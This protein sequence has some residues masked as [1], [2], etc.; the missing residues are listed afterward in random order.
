M[1][2]LQRAFQYEGQQVRTK[3]V[4]GRV[5]FAAKDIC[6]ILDI[7]NH[8]NAVAKLGEKQKGTEVMDTP[9]GRQEMAVITEAGVYKIAFTSQERSEE[10]WRFMEWFANRVLPSIAEGVSVWTA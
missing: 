6:A 9:G 1:N 5:W 7:A 10:T 4:D 8:R 3:A 2:Q